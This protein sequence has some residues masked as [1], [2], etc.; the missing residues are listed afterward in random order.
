MTCFHP[1]KNDQGQP[2][3]IHH[4]SQETDPSAWPDP[5]RRVTVVPGGST[6]AACGDLAFR[7]WT[8]LPTSPADWERLAERATF[9][10]P[11]FTGHKKPASGVVTIEPDGRVWVVS[12]TNRFG[13]YA[14]TFPKGKLDKGSLSFKA[15]AL[16]EAAE[17]SGLQV[18][19]IAHLCDVERD[20]S[21][22]RY[23][24]ARRIGGTPAD[25]GWESQATHLVPRAQLVNYVTHKNDQTVLAALDQR[26]P[27]APRVGDLLKSPTLDAG[28]RMVATVNGFRRRHGRWPTVL[29]MGRGMAEALKAHTLTP[30]AWL[31]LEVK[32]QVELI[33]QDT[34]CAE[35]GGLQYEY[36][37]NPCLP[38]D[39]ERADV[40]IWGTQLVGGD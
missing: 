22:T 11:A 40:W 30:T 25:M 29:Q 20:T 35:G 26:L 19:L 5:T 17:E 32:M 3:L 9:D 31:M 4:P 12:P 13:G 8:D 24:L 38:P 10:E 28:Q 23:Y 34:L 1:Q 37:A 36:D 21:T 39:A 18:A 16:K 14:H 15:N 7:S 6:P 2:V 33:D 27:I